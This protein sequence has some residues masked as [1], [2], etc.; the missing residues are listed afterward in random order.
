MYISNTLSILAVFFSRFLLYYVI[1]NLNI[2]NIVSSF[3]QALKSGSDIWLAIWT[4]ETDITQNL[5]YF[6]IYGGLA[7]GGTL[8]VYFRVKLLS[9]G[10]IKC[11]MRI[12]NEMV[13][14]LVKAPINLFHDKTPKGRIYNR[15]SKDLEQ[16]GYSFYVYGFCLV[17]FFNFI[18]ALVVCSIYQIWSLIAMPIMLILGFLIVR[19]YLSAS[20][21][22]TR[23]EGIARSPI[24]NTLNEVLPGTMIIRAYKYEDKFIKKYTDRID[25]MFLVQVYLAGSYNWFG[26]FMDFIAFGFMVFLIVFAIL[27]QD[28]FTPQAIGLLLTYALAL[29]SSL[30]YFLSMCGSFSNYMVS[31]E[32]CLNFTDIVSEKGLELPEVDNKLES[33]YWPQNGAIEFLNYSVKYR[34]DTELVLKNLSFTIDGKKKIGIV[35]RTGSGKST[36]CL[37]LFRMLEPTEGTILID[38]VDITQIG[39]RTLRKKLTIIPQDPS[40]IRGTLRYNIDPLGLSNDED[41]KDVMTSIGF[42]YLAENNEKDLD[43]EVK[44]INI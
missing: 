23:M 39:L 17:S 24:L 44:I 26:I 43:M 25:K 41:I 10:I 14:A 21:D 40:L 37:S 31:M 15:L 2:K 32:R 5:K 27:L 9:V 11:G 22:L 30:F 7:I 1:S 18:G 35:G 28:K 42:W 19:F 29:Q 20:R 34:P 16:I 8:F 3:Y 33:E 6:G 13:T 12:H 4:H 38:G 36:I